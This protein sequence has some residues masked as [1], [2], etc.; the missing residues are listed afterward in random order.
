MVLRGQSGTPWSGKANRTHNASEYLSLKF[1]DMGPHRTAVKEPLESVSVERK[2]VVPSDSWLHVPERLPEALA[3]V[4][5]QL[6]EPYPSSKLDAITCPKK[7]AE[8]QYCGLIRLLTACISQ[9]RSRPPSRDG[10]VSFLSLTVLSQHARL[11]VTAPQRLQ[12]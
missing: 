3:D 10:P 7:R 5:C 1:I 6:Q 12:Q 4:L 2:C 8:N 11:T 9:S